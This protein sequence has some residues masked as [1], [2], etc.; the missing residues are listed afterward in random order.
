MIVMICAS[1][2]MIK[3]M[4]FL[5]N[6]DQLWLAAVDFPNFMMCCKNLN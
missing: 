3:Y 6:K 2:G 4:S 1:L 5:E